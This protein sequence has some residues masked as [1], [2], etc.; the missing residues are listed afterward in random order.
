MVRRF[1]LFPL[2][3]LLVLTLVL[4][5]CGGGSSPSSVA[6]TGTAAAVAD[7]AAVKA[8]RA[9]QKRALRRRVEAQALRYY[10]QQARPIFCGGSKRY[11]ALT[12]DDGP[13]PD[14]PLARKWLK[15]F[16]VEATFFLVGRN[17]A[18]Y[19]TQARDKT[20]GGYALGDHSWSHPYLPDQTGEEVVRQ[21]VDTQN[22]IQT[23][24]GTR[25]QLF[26]PPY[27]AH[28][29]RVDAEAQR[30][31]MV[32]VLW[33]VDSRD[34]EG[35]DH[36]EIA[37]R[38]LDGIGPGAIV[39]MHENRGQTIRALWERILPALRKRHIKLVTVPQ[40]LAVNPPSRAQLDSP[41]G[42]CGG[43]SAGVSSE[44]AAAAA[45]A[46]R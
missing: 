4:G 20:R 27:G 35:A 1:A 26:R 6:T 3:S 9:A 42:G 15:R 32:Q 7:P 21:L 8:S 43:T 25:V 28:D 29:A 11:A 31:G 30:L 24:T 13:G 22:A 19:A 16:G 2:L 46:A 34:S 17:V 40:L 45:A 36:T 18:P 14:T 38:V 23:A 5:A 39:L 41:G 10:A 37:K 44:G 12:F 33:N